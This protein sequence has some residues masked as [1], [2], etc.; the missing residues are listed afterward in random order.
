MLVL[1][2]GLLLSVAPSFDSF[3]E[4]AVGQWRGASYTWQLD[5][6][7]VGIGQ[8]KE[9]LLPLSVAP[10]FVTTPSPSSTLV[11][12]VMR[13]CGGAVQG[14]EENRVLSIGES[15]VAL[16]RQVDG[17]TFFSFG[18]WASAPALL[19]NAEESD[20]LSSPDCFGLSVNI[21]H[22]DNT[23]RRLLVV[24][25][26]GKPIVA[27]VAVEA[28]EGATDD[29]V[30]PVVEALLSQRL[31]CI[32]EANAWEGGASTL[33]LSGMPPITSAPWLNARTRW[34]LS[35]GDVQGGSPLV[36]E[37][38]PCVAHLPGGCWVRV[39]LEEE[40]DCTLVEVG[41]LSPEAAE[42]KTISH[43]YNMETGSL[44]KVMFSKVTAVE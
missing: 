23:R 40:S 32:V 35:V 37:P 1:V 19:S 26:D 18:S 24:V 15:T 43:I 2:H 33:A 41:S 38:S 12:P 22:D 17:T 39:S 16:N 7:S 42:V 36:P 11:E 20:L 8:A 27:D 30:P 28:L 10:G 34:D 25:S 4:R 29:E 21:A 44:S 3:I 5:A 9:E 31:Q 6:S 14:V 13:S